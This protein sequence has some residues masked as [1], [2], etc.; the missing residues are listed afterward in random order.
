MALA[1]LALTVGQAPGA[2]AAGHDA[3]TPQAGSRTAVA[4]VN[5][6]TT[7]EA[8]D[9]ERRIA[10]SLFV[11]KGIT[12]AKL[13][14]PANIAGAEGFRIRASWGGLAW[15]PFSTYTGTELSFPGRI[16]TIPGP[17]RCYFVKYN[18]QDP[19]G[20]VGTLSQITISIP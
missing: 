17:C 16:P 18:I 12:A 10:H 7:E 19:T 3:A 8:V 13:V 6:L 1:A 5:G 11:V 20:K 4:P 9:V 15:S 14:V 2:F